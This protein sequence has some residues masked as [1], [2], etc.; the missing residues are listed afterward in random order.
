MKLTAR[1]AL[2]MSLAQQGLPDMADGNTGKTVGAL[3]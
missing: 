1:V 3:G 2:E